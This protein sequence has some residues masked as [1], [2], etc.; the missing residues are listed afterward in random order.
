M[1]VTLTLVVPVLVG[2]FWGAPLVAAELETGTSQFAW[3][4]SITRRRWL[5][6]KV[7]WLLSPRRSGAAPSPP[8]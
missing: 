8:S 4:Q 7:G 6:V 3:M 5:T 2:L 1:L